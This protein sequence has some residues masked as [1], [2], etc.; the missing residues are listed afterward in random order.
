MSFNQSET[1]IENT[2][3]GLIKNEI[4][5]ETECWKS[6]YIKELNQKANE[7]NSLHRHLNEITQERNKLYNII[8]KLQRQ[9]NEV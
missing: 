8:K 7:C 9:L 2:F 5:K 4:E 1:N 3:Y 6:S